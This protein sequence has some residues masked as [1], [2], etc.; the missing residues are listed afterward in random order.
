[1]QGGEPIDYRSRIVRQVECICSQNAKEVLA[2]GFA[3]ERLGTY[4][5]GRKAIIN[6]DQIVLLIITKKPP[7]EIWT[8]F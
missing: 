2:V 5:F 4:F 6:E 8:R 1:M 3:L 7:D